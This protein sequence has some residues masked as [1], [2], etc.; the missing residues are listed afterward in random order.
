MSDQDGTPEALT[1]AEAALRE[2][3][4]QDVTTAIC[5]RSGLHYAIGEQRTG[6]HLV[7]DEGHVVGEIHTTSPGPFQDCYARPGGAT[8]KHGPYVSA[9]A[10]AAALIPC[11]ADGR[12]H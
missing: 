9:R 8:K 2:L 11:E 7:A 10:A 4:R 5:K 6:P 12:A 1:T 3:H